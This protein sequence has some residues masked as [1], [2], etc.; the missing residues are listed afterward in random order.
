MVSIIV[1]VYNAAAYILD[2]IDMVKHQSYTDW[3][4]ILVDDCSKDDSLCL[5]QKYITE[6]PDERIH[7]ISKQT[8]EGAAR[9]RNTGLDIAKGRYIAFLDADDLWYADKLAKEIYFMEK[10]DV[11]FV[12]SGYDFGDEAGVPTGKATRVP[13]TLNYKQALTRTVIF[14]STVL[15]DTEKVKK[16]LIYMPDVPSEDSATWWQILKTG[17]VAYGINESL[18]IYRRP[19]QS[20]SSDKKKAVERIWNLYRHREN[21]S[22]P[23]SLICMFLW[24][25]RATVRR[26][27][28]AVVLR[29]IDSA[30]R[31][32][33][34]EIYILE[35]VTQTVLFG[36]T[37][38]KIFYPILS[39]NRIS[40][41]GFY[42]GAGLKLYFKGHLLI[43]AI[44][45]AILILA[46]K[47]GKEHRNGYQNPGSVIPFQIISLVVVNI[48]T[49][50]QFSMIRN[51]LIDP[52]P[53][54]WLTLVQSV[55]CVI[56]NILADHIY[57]K[58]FPAKEMLLIHDNGST[59]SRLSEEINSKQ[60]RFRI[61]RRIDADTDVETLKKE[62][63]YWYGA[64]ILENL[65]EGIRNEIMEFCYRHYIRV[66]LTPS[67]SDLMI[68]SSSKEDIFET[69]ILKI[70]EYGIP[71]EKRIIKR[72][73]DIFGSFIALIIVSP[74]L[75]T[76]ML[77]AK[78]RTGRYLESDE[79]AGKGNRSITLYRFPNE[80]KP[81]VITMLWSALKGD[82]SIVGPLPI[83]VQ[84]NEELLE[85]DERFFNRLRVKPGITG[86]SQ[87]FGQNTRSD[88]DSY[89]E[90]SLKLDQIYIQ[91]YSIGMDIKILMKRMGL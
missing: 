46:T 60:D 35:C 91:R 87:M 86:Y 82:I 4:L 80:A 66:Y 69:P 47:V 26:L 42:F 50:F 57:R 31:F 40:K 48:V 37:W 76:K 39:A 73:I 22:L 20:L 34:L 53:M 12:F 62:C 70:K 67:V 52:V 72:S 38:F 45:F 33:A 75:A 19:S 2:T 16:S 64:V 56:W 13:T 41:E 58:V 78:K 55:C 43:L 8:N 10:R 79:Y 59:N 5:M 88:N 63:L 51:W 36:Y 65:D 24:A 89:W 29:Y 61:V 28:N 14:T 85:K 90:N 81:C 74:V 84:E 17:V 6:K 77:M 1:P 18:A 11:G 32:F 44:Y 15:I 68:F 49:Y 27:I 21:L 25:F 9:A 23:Q 83:P 54:I 3:E 30:K 71:W 7:V